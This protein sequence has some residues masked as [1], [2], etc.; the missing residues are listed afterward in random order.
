MRY[1]NEFNVIKHHPLKINVLQLEVDDPG[2]YKQNEGTNQYF[3][4]SYIKVTN[5]RQTKKKV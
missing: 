1:L 5:Y 3:T 2:K 4:Q